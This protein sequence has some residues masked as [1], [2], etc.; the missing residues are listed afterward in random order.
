MSD[1]IKLSEAMGFKQGRWFFQKCWFAPEKTGLKY[2]HFA[3]KGVLGSDSFNPFTDANDDY[4]VLEW[5]RENHRV[6]LRR[7]C[8]ILGTS[9]Q[10]NYQIGNY[11]RAALKV[12]DAH[13]G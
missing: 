13:N 5:I 11:A 4:A 3:P 9:Y 8:H 7:A 6:E 12:I 10:W 2:I 1:R